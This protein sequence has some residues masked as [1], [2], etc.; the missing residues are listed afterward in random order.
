MV[1]NADR[2][3]ESRQECINP[4]LLS[5]IWPLAP[6]FVLSTILEQL[7]KLKNSEISN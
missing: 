5:T 1:V 3:A 6:W 2:K 7:W 4:S